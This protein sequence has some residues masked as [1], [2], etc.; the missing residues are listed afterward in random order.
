MVGEAGGSTKI[1]GK[2]GYDQI[3]CTNVQ[4]MRQGMS[5]RGVAK[6]FGILTATLLS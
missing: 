4:K 2:K 6:Q 3:L 5:I 1:T